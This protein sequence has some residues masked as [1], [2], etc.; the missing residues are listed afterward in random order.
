MSQPGRIAPLAVAILVIGY[1]L[2]RQPLS[3]ELAG[4]SMNWVAVFVVAVGGV[5]GYL[6]EEI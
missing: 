2:I 3:N 5:L 1:I 6:G 4:I